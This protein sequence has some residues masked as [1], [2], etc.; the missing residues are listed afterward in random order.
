MTRVIDRF[1]NEGWVKNEVP[2]GTVNGSNTSFTLAFTP[3]DPNA[4]LVY[5]DGLYE[6]NVTVSG[7]TLTFTAAPAL[8]QSIIVNYTKKL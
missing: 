2:T 1:T 8:G 5:L 3:D 6:P 7:T 4:V